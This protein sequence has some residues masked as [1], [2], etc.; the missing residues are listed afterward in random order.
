MSDGIR[1]GYIVFWIFVMAVICGAF[2]CAYLGAVD[3]APIGEYFSEYFEHDINTQ[4]VFYKALRNNIIFGCV[5]L[6]G[7]FFRWGVVL[8]SAAA[9]KEGF[10]TGFCCS[11]LARSLGFF[12]ACAG[13]VSELHLLLFLPVLVISSDKS[14]KTGR[15]FREISKKN[16]IFFVFFQI[17]VIT[18]FCGCA[19]LESYVNTTFMGWVTSKIMK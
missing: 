9:F 13:A 19:F 5:L 7:G 14:I 8:I 10:V 18:I 15:N 4:S 1:Q 2:Y 11:S 6:L 17:F 16:K 3:F 12:G